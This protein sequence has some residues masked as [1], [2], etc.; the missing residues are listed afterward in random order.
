MA[1]WYGN[2]PAVRNVNEYES[3]K[4]SV[5]ESNTAGVASE[6]AVCGAPSLLVHV[7]VSPALM[8]IVGVNAK[9]EMSVLVIARGPASMALTTFPLRVIVTPMG[10]QSQTGLGAESAL[11][12]SSARMD[13]A[14]TMAAA[15]ANVEFLRNE[16]RLSIA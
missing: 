6:V 16:L 1:Q 11:G 10:L 12:A 14:S 8:V 13:P 3:F 7:T 5:P 15:I 4:L 9:F 2:E